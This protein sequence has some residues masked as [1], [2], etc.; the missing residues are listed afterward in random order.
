MYRDFVK[1]QEAARSGALKTAKPYAIILLEPEIESWG[2]VMWTMPFS[3]SEFRTTR[4]FPQAILN[5]VAFP[6]TL[7]KIVHWTTAENICTM[8]GLEKQSTIVE[9]CPSCHL[10]VL[11]FLE[12]KVKATID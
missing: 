6:D 11:K 7:K 8:C 4:R 9:W 1:A 10:L 3:M 12:K 2:V 5:S